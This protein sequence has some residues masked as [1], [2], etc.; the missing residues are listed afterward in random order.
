MRTRGGPLWH[1]PR[2]ELGLAWPFASDWTLLG[3]L[4]GVLAL[5]RPSFV[6]DAPQAVH[7]AGLFS[8]RAAVGVELTL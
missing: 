1:G 5:S 7:R 3:R 8:L 6:L 2:A 4:G